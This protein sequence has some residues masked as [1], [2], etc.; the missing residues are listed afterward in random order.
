MLNRIRD[1]LR[2]LP[3]TEERIAMLTLL[4]LI[5]VR[6]GQVSL[7]LGNQLPMRLVEQLND[8]VVTDDGLLD[9]FRW[10]AKENAMFLAMAVDAAKELAVQETL[11]PLPAF[12]ELP[13]VL[14]VPLALQSGVVRVLAELLE[15]VEGQRLY[16]PWDQTGQ[17]AAYLAEQ[18]HR[19]LIENPESTG[20][21]LM[22]LAYRHMIQVVRNNPITGPRG[23]VRSE[24]SFGGAVSFLPM[25]MRIDPKQLDYIVSSELMKERTNS[26]A[27]LGIR[28]LL[29][30]TQGR[31][32]VAVQTNVLFSSGAEYNLRKELL[33]R[34]WLKAVIAMPSGLLD[35]TGISFAIL[36]IERNREA[37]TVR[38]VNADSPH[39]KVAVGRTRNQMCNVEELVRVALGQAEHEEATDVGVPDILANDAQLQVSRY[40][41]P[42]ETQLMQRM[43]SRGLTVSLDDIAAFI[44]PVP[45]TSDKDK[46]MEA[47]EDWLDIT[48]AVE[49]VS[50][51]LPEFGYLKHPSKE[52][53]IDT[54]KA[55]LDQNFLRPHDIVLMTK[56]S[57]GKVGIA[58]GSLSPGDSIVAGQ[59][60]I[61]LRVFENSPIDRRALFM[62]LRSSFGQA[63]LRSIVSGASLPLIQLKELKRLKVLVPTQEEQAGAIHALEEEARLQEQI[64][65]LRE[66]QA[67]A[68]NT[69]WR[70]N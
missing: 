37:N 54:T 53:Y 28:Q 47:A 35:R 14:G 63:L 44:R 45:L 40:V 5:W 46:L 7:E 69:L 15:P 33:L 16:A 21:S 32:V 31:I 52:V 68:S 65:A 4:I 70:L 18:G 3:Q 8:F 59:S 34:G 19:V 17:L 60:A 43:L 55:N 11:V 24:V 39:F 26:A 22:A 50:A 13:E 56:G 6:R 42:Q 36:I 30:S 9:E 66:Q 29:G 67:R 27:V 48:H 49:V 23:P 25:G 2:L 61:V 57:T 62:Q 41:V 64:D 1:A 12:Y 10:L 20:P 38:F 51:D 58:P